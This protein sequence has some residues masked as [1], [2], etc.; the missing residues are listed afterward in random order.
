MTCMSHLSIG[1]LIMYTV[2]IVVIQDYRINIVD[3]ASKCIVA[4][5][6]IPNCKWIELSTAQVYK[7]S[8]A[9]ATEQ[10]A[11]AGWTKIA[12][13][14]YQVEELLRHA[15]KLQYVI[16]RPAIVYGMGDLTGLSMAHSCSIVTVSDT[17]DVY[18]WLMCY[19]ACMCHVIYS[20]SFKLRR[21]V[22][23]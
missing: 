17:H 10:S 13:F 7:P 22:S 6:S 1:M 23:S 21:R 20:S 4:C 11:I 9:A 5:C 18:A 8:K 16:L 14:R 19:D 15:H 3:A 12:R 2:Y